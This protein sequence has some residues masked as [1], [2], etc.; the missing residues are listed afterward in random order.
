MK[1]QYVA[2]D[3]AIFDTERD[4]Y[5]HEKEMYQNARLMLGSIPHYCVSSDDV[6]PNGD[7]TSGELFLKIENE[8]HA[9]LFVNWAATQNLTVDHD[10]IIGKTLVVDF[11][12]EDCGARLEYIYSAYE[13]M[14]IEDLIAKIVTNLYQCAGKCV[15]DPMSN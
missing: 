1:T 2:D 11:Y 7:Y 9:D 4:C 6:F 10:A 8:Q 12:H 5:E 14:T 3:G 13:V 15:A